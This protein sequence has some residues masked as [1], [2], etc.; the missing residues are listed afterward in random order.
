MQG[1]PAAERARWA[2]ALMESVRA[3]S[4]GDAAREAN[5]DGD[6]DGD[7]EPIAA[8]EDDLEE[9]R[10]EPPRQASFGQR[11]RFAVL[12][13]LVADPTVVFADEPSSSLDPGRATRLFA[14]LGRW[15][16]GELF[17]DVSKRFPVS[18]RSPAAVRSWL[19]RKTGERAPRTLVLVCH[20]VA[21][22]RREA[23][24]FLLIGQD[25][26]LKACFSRDEWD[27]NA[28]TVEAVLKL[29][30]GEAGRDGR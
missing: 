22:A 4:R 27:E 7:S 24:R 18:D 16:S 3:W 6:G 9:K 2:S 21:I 29:R 5:G 14:L 23:D 25:H 1:W 17:R 15:K 19:D 13:A 10:A 8:E 12:R 28:G 20:D 11:Q 26:T 30:G